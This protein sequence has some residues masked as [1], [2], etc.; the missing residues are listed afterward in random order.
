MPVFAQAVATVPNS[1][2]P[3]ARVLQW[4]ALAGAAGL[5][6]KAFGM[7]RDIAKSGSNANGNGS[8]YL[9]GKDAGSIL[10]TLTNLHDGQN[11]M[12]KAVRDS[13]D[14]QRESASAQRESTAA[15]TRSLEAFMARW[16]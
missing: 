5:L 1:W 14:A 4:P 6:I 10:T 2:D 12:V 8:S 13:A 7:L 11:E 15:I 9:S 3:I 16:T